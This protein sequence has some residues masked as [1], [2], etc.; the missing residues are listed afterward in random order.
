MTEVQVTATIFSRANRNLL[1]PS[2]TLQNEILNA[3]EKKSTVYTDGYPGYD[4]MKTWDFVHETVNHVEEYVRGEVHT[5]DSR[6]IKGSDVDRGFIS[7]SRF[8]VKPS[9]L[10][11]MDASS[12][13]GSQFSAPSL[14]SASQP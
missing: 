14:S 6:I 9:M 1:P 11:S 7:G 3:I 5:Q 10:T 4:R 8:L 12:P 13:S 2:K